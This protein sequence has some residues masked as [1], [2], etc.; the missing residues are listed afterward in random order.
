MFT[1]WLIYLDLLEEN[2]CNTSFLR[3][4]TPIIFGIINSHNYDYQFG[5]GFG[6]N[7]GNGFGNGYNYGNDF[8]D[9]TGYGFGSNFDN[10]YYNRIIYLFSYDEEH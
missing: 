8:G 2:N 6:N 5:Y 9:G 1:D 10:S 4:I 3:L 7:F